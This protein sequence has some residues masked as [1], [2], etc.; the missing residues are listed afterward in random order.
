M[1]A[2]DFAQQVIQWQLK[3][4]RQNL[5]W[6]HNPTSYRVWVSEIMLQQ[7]QVNA[8]IPYYTRFMQKFPTLKSLALAPL[9][10][11]L[12][13]WS[14]LGYYARARNLHKTAVLVHR[15]FRGRLPRSVAGLSALPGIGRSTAGAIMSLAQGQR[16][17]I[18]DG[19]VKRVLARHS[20]VAGWPGQKR[21]HDALWAIATSH[22]PL[23]DAAIYNQGLMDL[24][25]MICTRSTPLCD[26]CP[27]I[28][29]CVAYAQQQQHLYPGKKPKSKARRKEKTQML[30]IENKANQVLLAKRPLNGIWGGLWCFPESTDLAPLQEQLANILGACL[31]HPISLPNIEHRFTHY[32]LT[33]TPIRMRA[34]LS[35]ISL[36]AELCW[37]DLGA[38]VPGGIPTPV[39]SLLQQLQEA[40]V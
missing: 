6:Q 3:H 31:N 13:L 18:L 40:R 26:A 7:T 11:V 33:I 34:G 12:S 37:Y 17:V 5:P 21:I 10:Q 4:G 28:R 27:L 1:A 2:D 16:A 32:D 39:Q 30:I 22:L 14:G 25:S 9:D 8:V 19:N 24:G 35:T 20:A 38:V 23:K 15:D 29:E 36:P